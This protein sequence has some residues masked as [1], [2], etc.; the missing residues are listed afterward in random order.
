MCRLLDRLGD[1]RLR[2]RLAIGGMGEVYLGEKV[3]PEGFVKPVVLKCVLPQLAQDEAFVQLFLD[4]ARLAALLNHPNIAQIY[5]FGVTDGVYYMAMEYV[6]G[7]TVDDIR[8]KHKSIDKFMPIEHISGVASQVCSALN[9]AHSLTDAHNV[10]LGLVHRDV[11]PH[12]LIVSVEGTVKLV[13]FGIAKAR[14]GLTRVQAK[15]AVGKFG[16]M[17]PEQSRGEGVDLRTDVFSLGVCLWELCTNRRL[18]DAKIDKPPDY[19]QGVMAVSAVRPNVPKAFDR[20]IS[21]ALAVDR[22]ERYQSCQDMHLDLERFLAAMTHYAGTAALAQYIKDLVE[23]KVEHPDVTGRSGM[24]EPVGGPSQPSTVGASLEEVQKYEEVFGLAPGPEK[25]DSGPAPFKAAPKSWQTKKK[26]LEAP[27][28]PTAPLMF[29]GQAPDRSN[30]IARGSSRPHEPRML[31]HPAVHSTERGPDLEKKA[32]PKDARKRREAPARGGR[33]VLPTV[34]AVIVFLALAGGGGLLATRPELLE[35][36]LLATG[37]KK[38][39]VIVEKTTL[40]KVVSDPP[41][42]ALFVDGKAEPN[43]DR[44]DLIPGIEYRFELRHPQRATVRAAVKASV[45]EGVRSLN[46]TL[47]PKA[48]LEVTSSPPGL[49]VTLNGFELKGLRTPA[50]LTDV[51]AG[52]ELRVSV[53]PPGGQPVTQKTTVAAGKREKLHFNLKDR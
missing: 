6:P 16:Y 9:Y 35:S 43:K 40:Y 37:L 23:G 36:I 53:Q 52:Q 17:S 1:Y 50:T 21:T 2:K 4:E 7:Y 14:A 31:E 15:G 11:S 13:D 26:E 27:P 38:V 3:G 33:S 44:L 30:E 39:E 25:S 22:N 34:L 45:G 28:V 5:D 20:I 41:D 12:N 24:V 42:A 18:H 47:P 48:T 32:P 19:R 51:P 49:A 46:F 8:R 29:D 10:S